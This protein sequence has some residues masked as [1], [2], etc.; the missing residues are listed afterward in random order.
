MHRHFVRVLFLASLTLIACGEDDSQTLA[1]PH[2][3]GI[4][5]TMTAMIKGQQ[6]IMTIVSLSAEPGQARSGLFTIEAR[7][8]D[9]T[10]WMKLAYVTGAGSYPLGVNTDTNAG[11]MVNV[12]TR[13]EDDKPVYLS[14]AA[15]SGKVL[16]NTL[17]ESRIAG[18][19]NFSATSI[20]SDMEFDA[21]NGVLDITVDRG[22]PALPTGVPN[23]G[24]LRIDGIDCTA[25]S[26]I[27]SAVENGK[28]E[29]EVACGWD[30][31]VWVRPRTAIEAP[32]NYEVPADVDLSAFRDGELFA[33]VDGPPTGFLN[34]LTIDEH[35]VVATF[36]GT[37]TLDG[38]EG[39]ITIQ[40]G[41][42][43]T[44]VE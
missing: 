26:V 35:R 8:R 5:G 40:L 6:R 2:D 29:L 28:F 42:V 38:G 41:S 27:G 16:V 23:S 21:S 11:G 43:N 10:I 24:S 17:T 25:S 3:N 9:A 1:P 15:M 18:T 19:F 36:G 32:G 34:V 14:T 20:L 39:T 44:S 33:S 30:M 12:M 22:L 37:L 13:D 4:H 31:Q 7:T